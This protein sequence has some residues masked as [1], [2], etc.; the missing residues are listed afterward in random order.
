[1]LKKLS[2]HKIQDYEKYIVVE[3]VAKMFVDDIRGIA[4]PLEIAKNYLDKKEL[5]T[6]NKIVVAFLDIA[7]IFISCRKP[8]PRK[9]GRII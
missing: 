5:D 6:L 8:F 7:E 4:C 3:Q 1:M 9:Y 2:F